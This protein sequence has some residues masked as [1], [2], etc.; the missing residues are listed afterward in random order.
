LAEA[1][2]HQVFGDHRMNDKREF[3]SV[4]VQYAIECLDLLHDVMTGGRTH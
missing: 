1:V 2:M 4:P 3:F